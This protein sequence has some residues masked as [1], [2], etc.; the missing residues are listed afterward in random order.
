VLVLLLALLFPPPAA[1]AWLWPADGTV[2]ERFAYDARAPFARG[3]RRGIVIEAATGSPVR[4]ACA[5]RVRFAGTAGANGRTVTVACGRYS[6][7]YLALSS[8]GVREGARVRGGARLGRAGPDGVRFGV[9][10][11][12][13]R[14]A[15]LDPLAF[16]PPRATPHEVPPLGRAPR[17]TPF[18]APPPGRLPRPRPFE[19]AAPEGAPAVPLVAWLGLAAA[20]C[21]LVGAPLIRLGRRR[22]RRGAAA[23]TLR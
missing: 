1:A 16:L 19:R 22:R 4:A 20:A 2:V 18:R 14:W 7:T 9:R 11:R 13:D 17:G 6:T 8:I 23:A 15:Y 12:A 10:R 21:G 3:A 5:G